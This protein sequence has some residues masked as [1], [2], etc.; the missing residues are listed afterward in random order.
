[1]RTCGL[2]SVGGMDRARVSLAVTLLLG[3]FRC[4]LSLLNLRSP[5]PGKAT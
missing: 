4:G 1:M 2:R 3:V 5:C